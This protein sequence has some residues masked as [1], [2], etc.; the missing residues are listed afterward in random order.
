MTTQS[1]GDAASAFRDLPSMLPFL[2]S[3]RIN[4]T[5]DI[6]NH[7]VAFLSR[8]VTAAPAHLAPHLA[9]LPWQAAADLFDLTQCVLYIV[10]GYNSV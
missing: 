2:I 10:L 4:K 3:D 1:S 8:R 5:T 6:P 7:S 9:G